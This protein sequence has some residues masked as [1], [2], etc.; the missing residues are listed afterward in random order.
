VAVE[1]EGAAGL[2]WGTPGF[3]GF[4]VAR[5]PSTTSAVLAPVAPVPVPWS[6]P[7]T[8]LAAA[9]PANDPP[10][11][12]S[13]AASGTLRP[14]IS[15]GRPLRG[16]DAVRRARERSSDCSHTSGEPKSLCKSKPPYLLH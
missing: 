10:A 3:S 8:A 9:T 15:A 5:A 13:T 16:A 11:A 12:S 2:G 1:L 14:P 7:P 4:A 6:L